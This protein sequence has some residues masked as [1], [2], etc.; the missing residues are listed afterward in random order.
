MSAN[1][2]RSLEN[3]D[4][5]PPEAGGDLFLVNGNMLPLNKAGSFYKEESNEQEVLEM[6]DQ[7]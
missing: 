1:D 3:M 2:I 6:D 4:R 7:R 5:I